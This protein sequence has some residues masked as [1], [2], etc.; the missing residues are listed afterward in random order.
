MR[1]TMTSERAAQIIEQ[2]QARAIHGP[3]SDQLDKVMTA[4]ERAEVLQLWRT[5]PGY[6]CFVDALLRIKQGIPGGVEVAT[7]RHAP[8]G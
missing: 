5:M 7:E 6:T 8:Q 4:E 3:W 2:A 1:A